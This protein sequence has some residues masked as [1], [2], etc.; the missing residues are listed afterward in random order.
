[1]TRFFDKEAPLIQISMHLQM[2]SHFK[3]F[4]SKLLYMVVIHYIDFVIKIQFLFF[5]FQVAMQ[6]LVANT[7]AFKD[8]YISKEVLERLV[9]NSARRVILSK[10]KFKSLTKNIQVDLS[11]LMAISQAT[12]ENNDYSVPRLAKLYTKDEPS[13]RFILILEGRVQVTIGQVRQCSKV[14]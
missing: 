3:K 14:P 6:W 4:D 9:K 7:E 13:D 10:N 1:M 11:S 2:V 8:M 5:R 12:G